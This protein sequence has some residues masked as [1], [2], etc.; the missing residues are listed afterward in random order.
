M[1][2]E[3]QGGVEEVPAGI[4]VPIF[5]QVGFHPETG[6]IIVLM[7]EHV[8]EQDRALICLSSAQT[9]IG[10]ASQM[11][12]RQHPKRPQILVPQMAV[13]GLKL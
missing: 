2:E 3:E 7:N 6:E 13:R 9:F 8:P 11:F 12:E 10:L 5:A 4:Q 1:S